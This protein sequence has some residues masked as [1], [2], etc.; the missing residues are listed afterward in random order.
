MAIAGLC[1]EKVDLPILVL[2]FLC[3]LE[4]IGVG[5]WNVAEDLW[6]SSPYGYRLIEIT[7]ATVRRGVKKG[8]VG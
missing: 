2:V 8:G 3:W 7:A 4:R 6:L 5:G 1:F